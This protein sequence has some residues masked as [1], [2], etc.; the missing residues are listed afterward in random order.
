MLPNS[1]K[2]LFLLYNENAM[3]SFSTN[4]IFYRVGLTEIFL[5]MNDFEFRVQTE[6]IDCCLDV[7][8]QDKI[9]LKKNKAICIVPIHFTLSIKHSVFSRQTFKIHL[10]KMSKI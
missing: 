2:Y 3:P 1:A 7:Q 8:I 4:F 5:Q 6:I 10:N 9:A